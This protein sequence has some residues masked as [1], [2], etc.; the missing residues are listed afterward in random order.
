MNI[1]HRKVISNCAVTSKHQH[2][3]KSIN[4]AIRTFLR[5]RGLQ[6]VSNNS[7]GITFSFLVRSIDDENKGSSWWQVMN[8]KRWRVIGCHVHL[9]MVHSR[10]IDVQMEFLL[11]AVAV[12]RLALYQQPRVC[13]IYDDTITYRIRRSLYERKHIEH[14]FVNVVLIVSAIDV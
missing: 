6:R 7:K 5:Q 10:V 11:K 9:Q 8:R 13:L 3:I 2:Y 4:L 12:S 14:I 1:L